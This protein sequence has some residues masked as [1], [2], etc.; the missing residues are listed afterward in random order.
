MA[1]I[2]STIIAGVGAAANAVQAYKSY[3][4]KKDADEAA[5][6]ATR[7]LKALTEKNELA[8]VQVPRMGYDL[9]QQNL[10]Q[11]QQSQLS[12]LQGAGMEALLG[13]VPQLAQVGSEQG[14][15]IGAG[16]QEA[17]Y[18]RDMA[19]AQ[20]AQGIEGRRVGR[21]ADLE[22]SRLQGAQMASAQSSMNMQNAIAGGISAIGQGA[23]D[24]IAQKD[25]YNQNAAETM[26]EQARNDLKGAQLK[27][28]NIPNPDINKSI[29]FSFMNSRVAPK[30]LPKYTEAENDIQDAEF[31]KLQKNKK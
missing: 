10:A 17:E 16:L 24:Y 3:Q 14:L 18:E 26:K 21:L 6:K 5:A 27:K 30:K 13:G 25:L 2:T 12:A 4:D 23:Q 29:D 7:E 1:A 8:G 9:A 28:T 19:V 20:N 15:K 11:Q 31:K 22:E